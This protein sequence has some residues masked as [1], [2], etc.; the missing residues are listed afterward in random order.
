MVEI[1]GSTK[2]WYLRDKGNILLN[3]RHVPTRLRRATYRKTA[4]FI[5]IT[6]ITSIVIAYDAKLSFVASIFLHVCY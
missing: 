6:T 5:V 1:T 3:R 4:I 2:T